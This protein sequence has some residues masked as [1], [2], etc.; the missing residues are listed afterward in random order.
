MENNYITFK[1]KLLNTGLFRKVSSGQTG[2]YRCQYCH[3]CND[4]KS[5]LYV[6]IDVTDD[7]P[8]LY[9]CQKCKNSG[10][11]G[12]SFLE[13]YNIDDIRIPRTSFRKKIEAGKVAVSNEPILVEGTDVNCVSE[14]IES[15]V[16]HYPTFADLQAFQYVG[17]PVQYVNDYL[18]G[19]NNLRRMKNRNWFRMSNGGII[20]RWIND[21]TDYRWIKYKS[22]NVQGRGLYTIKVPVD[23]YHPI[24]VYIAEGIMDVIGLYYNHIRDNN[25]YIACLGKEYEAGIQHLLSLGIFG[26][27]VNI[28]IFKDSN[29]KTNDIKIDPF[30]RKLFGKIEIYQNAI[31]EDYGVLPDKLEIEKCIGWTNR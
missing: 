18:G 9:Y 13:Y 5:H 19:C 26:D 6:K 30:V 23:L 14:Y 15:R 8:I 7:S 11:L 28:K 20:G 24:N 3:I 29:V 21:D 17:N 16:G 25:L 2:E 27:S 4:G 10:V 31:G 12:K 22:N 1:E